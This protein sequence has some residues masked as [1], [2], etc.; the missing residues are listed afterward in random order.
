MTPEIE[1]R[2]ADFMRRHKPDAARQVFEAFREEIVW[3]HFRGFSVKTTFEY[4]K[5]EHGV[6]CSLRT[7]ERWV[8]ASIDFDA[9]PGPSE[10][11]ISGTPKGSSS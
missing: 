5:E 9:E 2:L 6:S 1:Q 10:R 7:F 4:L 11:T 3:L 8:K